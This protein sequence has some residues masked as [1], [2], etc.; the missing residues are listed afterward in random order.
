[1]GELVEKF[2]SKVLDRIVGEDQ[3]RVELQQYVGD[4]LECYT[5]EAE[6]ELAQLLTDEKRQPITYN[7]YYTDNIQRSRQS[8]MRK[9]IQMTMNS[10][11]SQDWGGSLHISNTPLDR[12]KLFNSLERRIVV[13][14]DAQAC[15]EARVGLEAYY[16][17]K[18]MS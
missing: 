8:S 16:K 15:D 4:K 9:S 13:D 5:K 14:M 17:V 12:Q 1:M 11:I 7:H 6:Q 2:I 18:L 3:V 10:V